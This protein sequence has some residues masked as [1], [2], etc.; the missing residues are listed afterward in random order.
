MW[1]F[2]LRL[3]PFAISPVELTVVLGIAFVGFL[4]RRRTA[5]LGVSRG[6]LLDLALGALLGG[7][8]GARLIYAVPLWIRGAERGGAIFSAWSD[9]SAFFGGLLGGT[10][11]VVL[12]ARLKKL[13]VLR[14]MDVVAAALPAGFAFGK[15]GCFLAGCCYGPPCSGFACVAFRPGSLAYES[16]ARAG[17]LPAHAPAAHP[18]FPTQLLEFALAAALFGA[19]QL[20]SRRSRR[21]GETYLALLAGYSAWR[22]AVEFVRDDPGRHAFGASA[23]SD[24]QIVALAVLAACAAA[25]ALLRRRAPSASPGP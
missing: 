1:P 5:E 21:P 23:L 4:I 12:A 19:L 8:V 22:F 6:G 2:H 9:G 3:G 16:Q 25:W 18:V 11:G 7:A 14:V 24:S 13:P 15:V 10:L 17:L 20:L